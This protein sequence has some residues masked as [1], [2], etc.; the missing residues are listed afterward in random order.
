MNKISIF[1]LATL[2]AGCAGTPAQAKDLS[3]LYSDVSPSVV[4]IKIIEKTVSENQFGET[5]TQTHLGSGVVISDDG[6]VMTAAHVVHLAEVVTVML[7][8]G[9]SFNAEVVGSLPMADVALVRIKDP[10][11]NLVSAKLGDSDRVKTGDRIFIIGAPRGLGQTLTAGY[12]SG[13]R[14]PDNLMDNLVPV[15]YLQTDAAINVGNSGGPM[16]NMH[17]EVVGIVSSILSESGGFEGIGFVAAIN[18]AKELLLKQKAFWTG[19]ETFLVKGHLAKA[20]NIPQEAGLLV[21]RVAGNSPGKKMGLKPGK[22]WIQVDDQKLL[23]GGDI[24]LAIEDIPITVNPEDWMK[25]RV[26]LSE[27]SDISR[28]KIKLLRAGK[29]VYLE[30]AG[31][32]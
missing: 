8:S 18:T 17:G 3:Q 16:F 27:K 13:R 29:I 23:I 31:I 28:F 7:A 9:K 11:N 14:S 19:L 22:I 21:Q 15:E 4:V 32:E 12:I 2:L 10:P 26:V 1:L 25:V 24:I 5:D 30:Q 20:L 6:L